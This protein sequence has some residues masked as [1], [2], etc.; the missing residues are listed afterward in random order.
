MLGCAEH[1]LAV[2]AHLKRASFSSRSLSI[3]SSSTKPSPIQ[4]QAPSCLPG[5]PRTPTRTPASSDIASTERET[6]S[7]SITSPTPWS[8]R[9]ACSWP[10]R[11]YL[12]GG[13]E[14]LWVREH[15]RPALSPDDRRLVANA[16][17]DRREPRHLRPKHSPTDAYST[18]PYRCGLLSG[19]TRKQ[20]RP[21]TTHTRE[22][23]IVGLM[24]DQN[25][26]HGQGLGGCRAHQEYGAQNAP[27][28]R[29]LSPRQQATQPA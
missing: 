26:L 13:I 1:S 15:L 16:P 25:E 11:V 21:V 20:R 27:G 29:F 10:T 9:T 2:P 12:I 5:Y 14:L 3:G 19:R 23:H 6:P 22:H 17:S 4:H 7:R 8:Q 18:K 28:Q 24:L